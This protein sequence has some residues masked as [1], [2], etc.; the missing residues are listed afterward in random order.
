MFDP[1]KA[2]HLY[3]DQDKKK[4]KHVGVSYAM[5]EKYDGWYGYFDTR[6]KAIRSRLG[7]AIPS[8]EHFNER[9]SSID[10]DG[11]VIFEILLT[12]VKEFSTLNGI[13]NRKAPAY[14]A[15]LL[16]H[17]AYSHLAPAAPLTQRFATAKF[18]VERLNHPNVRMVEPLGVTHSTD[19]MKQQAELIWNRGGEGLIMKAISAPYEQ[20]KRNH[21][22]MKIKLEC[23]VDLLVVGMFEGEGKY[24]GTLGGLICVDRA[25]TKHKISGMTDEQRH[26]W[27]RTPAAVLNSVVEVNA[28]CKLP[29]GSLR[30]PRFKAIRYDKTPRDID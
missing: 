3:L 5:F 1:Q 13:L 7:R 10:F 6:D 18:C 4:P 29:N 14:N 28:M 23:T 30:E 15:Y 11:V 19:I 8:V 20:G 24:S 25:G 21:T 16:V 2:L 27:W 26:T 22:L 12:D 17:D 9:L